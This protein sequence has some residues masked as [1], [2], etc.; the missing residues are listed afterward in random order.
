MNKPERLRATDVARPGLA[1]TD[2]A[3]RGGGAASVRLD[4]AGRTRGE[5]Y[6][7]APSGN[8]VVLEEE[9]A[10]MARTALDHQLATGLYGKYVGMFR[11]AL[12]SPPS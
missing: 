6:E 4:P 12:G 3:H 7:V 10:R 2:P 9:M 1:R 11:T 8:A 5:G